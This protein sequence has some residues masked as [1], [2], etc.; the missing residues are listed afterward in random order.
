MAPF[1]LRRP[2]PALRS[3]LAWGAGHSAGV[4]VLAALA[5]AERDVQG[6]GKHI[7]LVALL[8]DGGG[9][10]WRRQL[11]RP[12]P[13]D[14]GLQTVRRDVRDGAAA[15]QEDEEG[16]AVHCLIATTSRSHNKQMDG[17]EQDLCQDGALAQMG[18]SG[19]VGKA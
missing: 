7:Q 9:L 14:I 4:V 10:H 16:L 19:W 15:D 3:G 1:S 5:R 12:G 18:P 11:E 6:V 8:R 17:G 2:L 13:E